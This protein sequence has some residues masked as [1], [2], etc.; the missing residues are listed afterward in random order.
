MNAGK[1]RAEDAGPVNR[2]FTFDL[3]GQH[4]DIEVSRA[5]I[6]NLHLPLL[7]RFHRHQTERRL[8]VFLAGPPGAGKTTLCAL[9]SRLA[10]E[11][12]WA[13]QS[14]SM[15]GFHFPNSQLEGRGLMPRKG[16][17]DSYECAALHELLCDLRKGGKRPWPRYDRA[18]HEPVPDAITPIPEGVIII[19]GN[20]MLLDRP[21]WRELRP[22][23]HLGGIIRVSYALCRER[24][25]ARHIRGGCDLR[26]A[27][28]K[29]RRT[30]LPNHRLIRAHQLPA[31]FAIRARRGCPLRA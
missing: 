28:A 8:I 22:Q 15:D 21:R 4:W 14:L 10:A 17:P 12:G 3:S 29:Y 31:D 2:R 18:L 25:V 6:A 16:I 1:P 24:V 7:E 11:A 26:N 30:D 23:A 9:W 19:E 20:Y 5:E 27:I 13:L